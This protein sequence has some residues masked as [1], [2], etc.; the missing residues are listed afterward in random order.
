MTTIQLNLKK[1]LGFKIVAGEING[2]K[3]LVSIGAK[4][5]G[6]PGLKTIG[7]THAASK[8]KPD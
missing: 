1:L 8:V 4:L 6:K 2:A 5:G 3:H 7:K